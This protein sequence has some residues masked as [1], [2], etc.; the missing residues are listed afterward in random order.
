MRPGRIGP[1][2]RDR[3]VHGGMVGGE[4]GGD[5]AQPGEQG[6]YV[7]GEGAVEREAPAPVDEVGFIEVDQEDVDN[8]VASLEQHR[9]YLAALPGHPAPEEMIPAVLRQGGEAGGVELGLA[10]AAYQLRQD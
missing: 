8:A 5:E 1:V 4:L 10:V 9:E 2:G 7:D 3:L 6:D